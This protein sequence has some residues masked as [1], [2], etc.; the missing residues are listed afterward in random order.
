LANEESCQNVIR[1][2]VENPEYQEAFR[3]GSMS[4]M[5]YIGDMVRAGLKASREAELAEKAKQ[6]GLVPVPKD[7]DA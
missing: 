1:A 6:L 2:A 3:I 7:A 5:G 4:E